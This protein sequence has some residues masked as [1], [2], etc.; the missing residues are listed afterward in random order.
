M[1]KPIN[2][3]QQNKPSAIIPAIEQ[4]EVVRQNPNICEKCQTKLT[5]PSGVYPI[6]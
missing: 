2:M 5:R 4:G 6:G 3:H 1:E